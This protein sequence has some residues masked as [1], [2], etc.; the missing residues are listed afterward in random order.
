MGDEADA[1][2]VAAERDDPV[3]PVEG[4]D[5][6]DAAPGGAGEQGATLVVAPDGDV[7][8]D[9]VRPPVAEVLG[10]E[11]AG[12]PRG[13]HHEVGRGLPETPVVR[14]LHT[15][16]ALVVEE[17]LLHLGALDHLDALVGGVPEQDVVEVGAVH[18]P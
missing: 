3:P 13:V 17:D 9:V 6:V 7:A 5:H 18:L 11:H 10:G 16:G 4:G 1:V 14:P 12:T 2:D 8:E 15:H